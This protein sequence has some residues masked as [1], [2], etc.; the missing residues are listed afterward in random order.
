MKPKYI[1]V[2]RRCPLVARQRIISASIARL[3][4][5]LPRL[6]VTIQKLDPYI[7][8]DPG[9]SSLRARRVLRDDGGRH[10]NRPRPPDTT[11]RFTNQPTSKANNV[12]TGKIYKSVIEK[13]NKGEY[14]VQDRAGHPAHHR[15]NQ[16]RIGCW[17]SAR[18][19]IIITEIGG[20]VGR[21]RVAAVHRVGASLRYQLGH[22]NTALVALGLDSLHGRFGRVEDQADAAFCSVVVGERFCSPTF[23]SLRTGIL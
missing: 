14:L 18:Y 3:L 9:R 2:T 8:V 20:T 10:R 23:S 12:T 13:E 5:G 21:H 7:N 11:R 6:S 4:Q 15:R 17:L 19:D 1:F 22:R 16:R